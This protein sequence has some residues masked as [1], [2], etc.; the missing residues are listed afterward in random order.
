MD[1]W[2]LIVLAIIQGL[3]EFLPIS[4]SAHLILLPKLTGWEDQGLAFDVTVHVGTLIAVLAYFRNDLLLITRAW[5][6]SLRERRQTPES[7][8]GWGVLV[9]TIPV[10]LVGLLFS[11][12]VENYLRS[13][14]VIAIATIVFGILLWWADRR[15]AR[16]HD[17]Y[18][19]RMTGI[20]LIGVAQAISIIPGTSRS[21]ITLTAGLMLGLT[22]QA[23]A[24]FSFLLSIPVIV[25]AGGWEAVKVARL[26]APVS[27]MEMIV[28]AVVA[29]VV[30]YWTIHFFIRLL[31]RIGMV[32]FVAYRIVLGIVL[33]FAFN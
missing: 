9:A 7:R 16:R 18:A 4:S 6:V 21:G 17:E 26:G 2:Q 29:G 11:S 28:G 31:D 14:T 24:R 20:L 27:W 19:L 32:P 23:A 10:G 8:L 22:R 3:T 30:A 15:G 1:L 25:L 5:L 13:P 33:L 12:E